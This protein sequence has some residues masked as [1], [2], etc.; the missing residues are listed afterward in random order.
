M[1]TNTV[2]ISRSKVRAV[3]RLWQTGRRVPCLV[4]CQA[5]VGVVGWRTCD[6]DTF[7]CG[8]G[9]S[10]I[11]SMYTCTRTFHLVSW[12]EPVA[13]N[14]EELFVVYFF[15]PAGGFEFEWGVSGRPPPPPQYR[16]FRCVFFFR[17]VGEDRPLNWLS[18]F[19]SACNPIDWSIDTSI[20]RRSDCFSFDLQIG[21]TT[22]KNTKTLTDGTMMTVRW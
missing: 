1:F 3:T 7:S 17:W 2:I 9:T 11:N 22:T 15:R 14:F 12:S 6:P 16:L 21:R 10:F 13:I 20:Y 8:P 18:S 4:W 5:Y 19:A